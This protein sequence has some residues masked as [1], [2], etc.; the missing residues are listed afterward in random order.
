MGFQRSH[1]N[2][3][4]VKPFSGPENGDNGGTNGSVIERLLSRHDVTASY[5]SWLVIDE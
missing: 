3:Q 5:A 4:K 1:S 2:K